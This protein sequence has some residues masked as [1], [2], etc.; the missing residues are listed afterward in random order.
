M[1]TKMTRDELVALLIQGAET[2]QGEV[3]QAWAQIDL[4]HTDL[5]GANLNGLEFYKC[6][7]TGACFDGTSLR[8]AVFEHCDLKDATFNDADLHG[9]E[10]KHCQME[11]VRFV[12]TDLSGAEI[13]AGKLLCCLFKD[14]DMSGAHLHNLSATATEFISVNLDQATLDNFQAEYG[15][16]W[17]CHGRETKIVGSSISRSS[18]RHF[19]LDHAAVSVS[20]FT[21]CTIERAHFENSKLHAVTFDSSGIALSE[22]HECSMTE[23]QWSCAQLIRTSLRGSTVRGTRWTPL[24]TSCDVRFLNPRGPAHRHDMI[25]AGP[26]MDLRGRHFDGITFNFDL[27]GADLRDCTFENCDF[28]GGTFHDTD[29]TG[30]KIFGGSV[31]DVDLSRAKIAKDSFIARPSPKFVWDA[32]FTG[33]VTNSKTQWPWDSGPPKSTAD[34]SD[35]HV[36][37]Q[38]AYG[39]VFGYE[40]PDYVTCKGVIF[41][42]SPDANNAYTYTYATYPELFTS[43]GAFSVIMRSGEV[44]HNAVVRIAQSVRVD[45]TGERLVGEPDKLAFACA[46]AVQC[47]SAS[48]ASAML[49]TRDAKQA[50][51]ALVD[52]ITEYLRK[53]RLAMKKQAK[54]EQA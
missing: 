20:R 37:Y 22:F 29:F 36:A 24:T 4:A 49:E 17:N 27:T 9:V 11:N 21:N 35:L 2:N 40:G 14:A 45:A 41:T 54:E 1:K 32:K 44:L 52:L 47:I 46:M 7:F 48:M 6:N 25:V 12:G 51:Q 42:A 23:T 3:K 8:S 18:L 15:C 10:L 5:S 53:N 19:D 28:Q 33:T 39:S 26:H 31:V 16:F 13:H 50:E 34:T 30:A 43:H 38:K